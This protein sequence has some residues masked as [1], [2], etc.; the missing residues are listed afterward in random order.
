[1]ADTVYMKHVHW[2][3]DWMEY[4]YEG[5]TP[6]RGG[7]VEVPTNRFEWVMRL[8]M[9]GFKIGR[10]GNLITDLETYFNEDKA[11]DA[12]EKDASEG[13]DAGRQPDAQDGVRTSTAKGRRSVPKRRNGSRRSNGDGARA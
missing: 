6:V 5:E 1:M 8:W 13:A 3:H 4:F 9:L 12:K 2:D 7:V 11:R 10:D